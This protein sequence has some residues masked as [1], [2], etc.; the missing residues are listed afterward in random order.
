MARALPYT[1]TMYKL[2]FFLTLALTLSISQAQATG[3]S[4]TSLSEDAC[5]TIDSSIEPDYLIAV[6]PSLGSSQLY[7]L[8]G[9]ARSWLALQ[10]DDIYYD[11]A[12]WDLPIG[13]G[14]FPYVEGKVAEWRYDI[15]ERD[16][17]KTI[18]P[19]A[20]IY[21]MGSNDVDDESKELSH[22]VVLRLEEDAACVLGLETSNQAARELA[23]N[24][25]LFC[26]K[27]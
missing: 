3:F 24:R 21:R 26:A 6:C 10:V 13:L 16:D 11:F 23:D 1:Q 8:A 15:V 17:R 20:L 22:L 12:P 4:Y 14:I 5:S 19:Y 25:A 9:D 27:G 2:L 18:A 7:Y